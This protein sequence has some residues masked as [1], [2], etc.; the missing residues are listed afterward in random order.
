MYWGPYRR[1]SKSSSSI[2][3]SKI[4]T[5]VPRTATV[6]P[7]EDCELLML[8]E[9]ELSRLVRDNPDLLTILKTF[10]LDRVMATADTLK[11][12]LRQK[13]VDGILH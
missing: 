13:R 9:T 10:H 4:R 6:V 11:T 5:G 7:L 12:F 8:G 1:E 3:A 2:P